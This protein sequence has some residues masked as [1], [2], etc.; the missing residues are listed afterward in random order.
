LGIK[1]GAYPKKLYPTDPEDYSAIF[2]NISEEGLQAL[3]E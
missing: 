2:S 3:D 1:I